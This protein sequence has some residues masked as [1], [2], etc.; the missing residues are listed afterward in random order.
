MGRFEGKTALVTGASVGVGA[1]V[2][3][4]LADEGALVGLLGRRREPL[5]ALAAET[6]GIVLR[7]DASDPS[8]MAGAVDS[9]RE[10]F[11]GL[12]VL[13]CCTG[14]YGYGALGDTTDDYW[15]L[16]VDANLK[17]AMV[18]ARAAMPDLV[19]RR[20]AMVIVSSVAGLTAGPGACGFITMK[21]ALIGLAKSI[22]IDYGPKGVRCNTVCPGWVRSEAVDMKLAELIQRK[23]LASVDEAYAIVTRDTPLGRPAT[24]EEVASA[25]AFLCSHEAAMITGANLTVDGGALIADAPNFASAA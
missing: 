6:G 23:G 10:W 15:A 18:A 3:R 11:G 25:I 22:A 16:T 20:G 21:H 8:E 19:A 4:R 13:A 7:A 2:A 5:E 12:D 9:V 1:A 24:S 14:G 17:A